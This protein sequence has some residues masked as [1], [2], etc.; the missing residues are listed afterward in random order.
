LPKAQAAA[1]WTN[2][3]PSTVIKRRSLAEIQAEEADFKTRQDQSFGK[4]AG[5]WFIE[6]QERANSLLQIQTLAKK[7]KQSIFWLKSR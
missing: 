4:D 1:P 6:R 3:K 5:S 2:K 7:N